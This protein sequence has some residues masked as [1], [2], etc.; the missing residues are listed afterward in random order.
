MV[1]YRDLM[2]RH[3]ECLQGVGDLEWGSCFALDLV[4]SG[5]FGNFFQSETFS[6]MHIEYGKIGDNLPDT[7]RSGKRESAC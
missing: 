7:A 1:Y 4:N 3:L 5:T 2:Y 6:G